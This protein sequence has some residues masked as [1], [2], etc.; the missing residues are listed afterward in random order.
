MARKKIVQHRILD[1]SATLF[2]IV[3]VTTLR[4]YFLPTDDESI[5][6]TLTPIGSLIQSVQQSLPLLSALVW[7]MMLGFAGLDAGRYGPKFS[8]YPAYTLMAIP[9]F[10]VIAGAVMVSTC[11]VAGGSR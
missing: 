7:A 9:I 10:G 3:V 5:A 11:S 8:L 2:V 6:N 4:S 1:L